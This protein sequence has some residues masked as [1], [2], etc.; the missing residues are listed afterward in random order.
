MTAVHTS[1]AD[2]LVSRCFHGGTTFYTFDPQGCAGVRTDSGANALAA[3]IFD[4]WGGRASTDG[5]DTFSGFGGKWGCYTDGQTGLVLMTHRFYDPQV[6]RFLTRDPMGHA[7]GVNL[8]AYTQ[9]DPV[10]FADPLG[11]WGITI[12]VGVTVIGGGWGFS[13]EGGVIGSGGI[14]VYGSGIAGKGWG[15]GGDSRPTFG[16][17]G[18]PVEPGVH[19]GPIVGQSG[20]GD[21][22]E[23]GGVSTTTEFNP[24]TGIGGASGTKIGP[25]EGGGGG[26]VTGAGEGVT[27]VAPWPHLPPYDNG[28]GS[29]P[30]AHGD[31]PPGDTGS[32]SNMGQLM[33]Q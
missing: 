11:L 4:V 19:S 24:T 16:W 22:G 15:F 9:N 28:T 23:G 6:G 10:N 20:F 32:C 5:A 1:G 26:L 33:P 27:V 12:G 21:I 30:S 2:G 7:G 18:D 3:D 13:G 17:T 14:G 8:Y 29:N 31:E 25:S